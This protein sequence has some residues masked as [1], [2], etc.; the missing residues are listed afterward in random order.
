[1]EAA[2]QAGQM[3]RPHLDEVKSSRLRN[4]SSIAF[5]GADRRTAVLGCLLGDSLATL[6]VPVAGVAPSHWRLGA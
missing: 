3:G 1:V 5:T 4:I 2:F 6:R